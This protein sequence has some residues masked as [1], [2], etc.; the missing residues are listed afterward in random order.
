MKARVSALLFTL[1][2]GG[3]PSLAA[4]DIFENLPDTAAYVPGQ[5]IVK[6]RNN[7]AMSN[8]DLGR[9]GLDQA[10]RQLSGGAFLHQIPTAT[11]GALSLADQYTATTDM[12]AQ[13][14]A[15]PNVE[16]AHLNYRVYIGGN[17][18][19]L[20]D[21]TP[22]DTR[23]GEQWHYFNNGTAAGQSRG[24]IG[25]PTAWT[26]GTGAVTSRVGILDTGILPNHVDIAGSGNLLPGF[27]MIT[28]PATANDGDGRDSDATDTGDANATGECGGA[29]ARGSSWHGTHVAGT[30]G[31]VRS[32]NGTGVA[33]VNW[34]VGIV[35]VRVLGK[36]G[37]T[38]A[39]IND[40]IRWAAGLP[41]PGVPT[42]TNPVRI[43]S[44]SLGAAGLQCSA[45]P[46]TQSAI[47]DAIAA[48]V[49]VVVAAGNEAGDAANAMPASCDGVVTVAASDARGRLVTRY[50]NFGAD[51][52]IMAPGGDTQRDDDNNGNGD[53]VLSTI[54]GGYAYYNG[55]SMATPHVSGVLALWA[56]QTPAVSN[57]SLLREMYARALPRSS[58][59]CPQACGAGLLQA[60]RTGTPPQ[61]PT[62]VTVTR[63]PSDALDEGA[64]A[65]VTARVSIANVG[66]SNVTVQFATD[67][68]SIATVSPTT[69]TTNS[70]GEA[71]TTLT[72][73]ARGTTDVTATAN[74]VTGRTP[75]RV[76]ALSIIAAIVVAIL[77]MVVVLLRKKHTVLARP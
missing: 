41:V 6:T 2:I 11:L 56:S 20:Q 75:V 31:A 72:A 46:S 15:D 65:T 64:T 38:L 48:G 13:L 39:D 1:A 17:V 8:Q 74:G 12:V 69:A 51:I 50:S 4:Q 9:M 40:G 36:C 22:N 53:G 61:Q 42:N 25:L 3:L 58:T 71:T 33:G 34:N 18:P 63:T 59:E 45:V 54:Q 37:G 62:I 19:L 77:M 73:V 7:A 60:D 10:S 68:P 43:I 67:D 49:M 27:D 66:Q 5:I 30:V 21:V 47:D 14:S 70:Q 44:M 28:D 23:Y 29:P 24:G 26:Q 35:P 32:N 55:T 76:P 16:Y 52:E 57:D